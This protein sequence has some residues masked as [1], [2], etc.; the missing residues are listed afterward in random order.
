MSYQYLDETRAEETYSLPDV[1][2]WE[3][4]IWNLE[5]SRGCGD[6]AI[7][8]CEAMAMAP[9]CCCPSCECNS[10]TAERTDRAGWFYQYGSPGYMP[11]SG[12]FGPYNSEQE[13]LEQAREDAGVYDV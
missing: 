12:T 6:F 10:G 5:C 9:D 11:D 8:T 13:A 2:V 4:G 1:E 7:P 3:D